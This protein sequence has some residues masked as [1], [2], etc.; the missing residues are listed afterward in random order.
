VPDRFTDPENAEAATEA[1]AALSEL[2]EAV[3]AEFTEQIDTEDR[4][5][6]PKDAGM[7]ENG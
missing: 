5:A 2:D 7:E 6:A 3:D 1:A 4:S